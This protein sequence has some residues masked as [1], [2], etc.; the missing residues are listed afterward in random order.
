MTDA[1]LRELIAARMAGPGNYFIASRDTL[2]E[3]LDAARQG[4]TI[5]VHPGDG[6]RPTLYEVKADCSLRRLP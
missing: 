5:S 1:E 2:P 4:D 6:G 3:A